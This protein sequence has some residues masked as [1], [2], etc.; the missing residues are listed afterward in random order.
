MNN[1]HTLNHTR[2]GHIISWYNVLYY[3]IIYDGGGAVHEVHA[4]GGRALTCDRPEV[5][6]AQ[7]SG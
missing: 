2:L 6:Q 3:T 1:N 5:L 7:G 4:H